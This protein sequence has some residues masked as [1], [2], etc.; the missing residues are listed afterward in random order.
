M[1][2]NDYAIDSVFEILLKIFEVTFLNDQYINSKLEQKIIS[3]LEQEVENYDLIVFTRRESDI[4][5]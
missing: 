5:S 2:N 1:H 3:F 4:S